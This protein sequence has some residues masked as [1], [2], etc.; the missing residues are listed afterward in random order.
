MPRQPHIKQY[1][2][3]HCDYVLVLV[4][5][6]VEERKS[7]QG[8]PSVA[9]ISSFRVSQLY[10]VAAWRGGLV[11]GWCLGGLP[12]HPSELQRPQLAGFEVG[13]A[14]CTF[15]SGEITPHIRG[16]A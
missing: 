12:G 13:G 15:I 1:W 5:V 6:L 4:P 3:Y 7:W 10:P 2:Y 16:N 9:R 14:F 8:E 11:L